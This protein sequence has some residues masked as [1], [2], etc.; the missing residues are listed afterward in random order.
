MEKLENKKLVEKRKEDDAQ[1]EEHAKNKKKKIIE[2]KL[3]INRKT[4]TEEQADKR[5]QI[6]EEIFSQM[7]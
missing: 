7:S 3:T 1:I 5:L 2:R 6:L 4:Q